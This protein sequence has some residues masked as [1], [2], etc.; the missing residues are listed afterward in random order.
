MMNDVGSE[1]ARISTVTI[2][3][4]CVCVCACV[5]RMSAK[6]EQCMKR[7]ASG[8]IFCHKS[9]AIGQ[10]EECANVER[11]TRRECDE[12]VLLCSGGK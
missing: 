10:E 8:V 2:A 11:V 1:C 9:L 7:C 6:R 4:I 5:Q 12:S 3:Y